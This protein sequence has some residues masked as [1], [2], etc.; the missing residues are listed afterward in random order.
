[1]SAP[2]RARTS[3]ALV[4]AGA[5]AL[6]LAL[7]SGYAVSALLDSEEFADRAADAL[8]SEAV[9]AEVGER[10]ADE[11]IDR[12]PDLVAVR[13]VIE[14][15]V[16]VTAR[17][18]AFRG[19]F[20][21]AVRDLHRAIFEGDQTTVTL[22]LLDIGA[23]ARG[24][25]AAV[26]PKLAKQIPAVSD[27]DILDLDL[28]PA[29]V[30]VIEH[31]HV[32]WVLLGLGLVGLLLGLGLSGDRRRSLVRLGAAMAFGGI[33]GFVALHTG[34]AVFLAQ[35]DAGAVRD[36]ANAIWDAFLSDLGIALLLF[37][38]CGAVVAAAAASLLK[39]VDIAA[40]L[41]AG[42]AR[43]SHVPERPLARAGRAVLMLLAGILIVARHDAFLD[44]FA[45]LIGIYIAYAG[46]AELMRLSIGTPSKAAE[47]RWR[48]RGLVTAI[49]LSAAAVILAGVV[50]VSVGGAERVRATLADTGCNGSEELCERR[51]DE[52]VIPATH[53]SMSAATNPNWFFAQQEAGLTQQLNE[54]IRG[55]LIDAYYGFPTEGGAV[56]TD[57]GGIEGDKR[58]K[59]EQEIGPEALAAALRIR[60]RI[61]GDADK[62]ERGVYLC[63][64]FCEVGA[65][66]IVPA[67]KEVRDFLAANPQ[68]VLVIVIED[69]VKPSDIA[70]AME[71]SGLIDYVFMGP[72][73]AQELPTLTELIDSGGRAV[74]MAE[75]ETD[76]AIPWYHP[77]YESLVQETPYSF[78]SPAEL[79]GEENL[80]ESC[81]ANRGPDNA[82]LFLLNHW[83]DTS[84][85]PK[86]SNA[87][88]VNDPTE[89]LGRARRCME[90][91][92][93][94]PN[95]LAIDFFRQGDVVAVADQLNRSQTSPDPAEAG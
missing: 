43:V 94:L 50:F 10:V 16:A 2:A 11:L 33:V 1:V 82:P 17:S 25:L 37:A 92:G 90:L 7:V 80:D 27:A 29:L 21:A 88:K 30:S 51:L 5:I 49:V 38:A 35:L 79:I 57:L 64:G 72:L 60:D 18:S 84:P 15:A 9:A 26:A 71:K 24:A 28:P 87:K 55:L 53:N 61:V 14:E 48:G 22:T 91:R 73:E 78:A 6:L 32:P 3:T 13:P 67:F 36:S 74:V 81:R 31:R 34:E 59:I 62:S 20:T 70:A 52:I 76:P 56:S 44:L 86:P 66:P 89:L 75:N 19:V 83:V 8:Q 45:I 12:E 95:L 47:G 46:A 42:W 93:R 39:P 68:E 23:T 4:V 63:H 69:Y 54:G 58:E 85:A 77:V 41:Q 40:P 65:L